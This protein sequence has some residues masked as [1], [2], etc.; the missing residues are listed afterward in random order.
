M[1]RPA[2]VVG[3]TVATLSVILLGACAPSL[4]QLAPATIVTG[5]DLTPYTQRGFLFTP[6]VYAGPYEAI[7]LITV[8][9]YAGGHLNEKTVQ[10]DFDPIPVRDV[11]DS[12][13]ARA[14]AM[15]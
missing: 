6:E 5:I 12:V 2:R 1:N 8:T 13:Y 11:L 15:G 3:G 9:R 7:G 4:R 14:L 10:W